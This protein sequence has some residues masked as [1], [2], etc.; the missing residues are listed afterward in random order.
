M[1]NLTSSKGLTA[2]DLKKRVNFLT[3]SEC[4]A[5]VGTS[6]YFNAAD[7]YEW[8]NRT[9]APHKQS[10]VQAWGQ[11]VEGIL[12]GYTEEALQEF[13]NEPTLHITRRGIRRTHGNGVMSCTLDAKIQD[14]DES[15]EAKTHAIIH[16]RVDMSEWG[17]DPWTD[18]VPPYVRDQVLFQQAVCPELVRTW[19]P[20]WVGGREP[21]IYCIE[22]SHHLARIAQ[23]EEACCDFWN[24]HILTSIPPA[25][26]P[27][28][29]T[30]RRD[31]TPRT[32]EPVIHLLDLPLEQSESLGAQI[33]TLKEQKDDVD[34]GI[35]RSL[36]GAMIG[37]SPKGHRVLISSYQRK[38]YT[39]AATQVTKMTVYVSK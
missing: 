19:V 17:T 1:R 20:F 8:K 21:I 29:D 36:S 27:G 31:I 18:A 5:I 6:P 16:G 15:I 23:I 7:V 14:R 4:P 28:L 25:M 39:V 2:R 13:L 3:A 33:K 37:V 22:R 34:A 35:R 30:I 12:L 10:K 24:E 11:R 26:A 32:M 38:E 9:L